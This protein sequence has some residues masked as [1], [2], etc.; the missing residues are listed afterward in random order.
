M[1]ATSQCFQAGL[2]PGHRQ[3]L[4]SLGSMEWVGCGS[5]AV[6]ERNGRTT[7]VNRCHDS[8][9]S[10]TA[11][12][13]N[14]NDNFWWFARDYQM[15]NPL[16]LAFS[17]VDHHCFPFPWH[18]KELTLSKIVDNAGRVGTASHANFDRHDSSPNKS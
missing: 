18:D 6:S 1:E 9:R 15:F 4:R 10:K 16:D 3:L 13:V 12:T 14:E 17:S 7:Q 5:A 8:P 11:L 2:W